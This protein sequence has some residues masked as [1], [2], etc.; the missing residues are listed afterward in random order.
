[1]RRA[2][3]YEY[4]YKKIQVL[5]KKWNTAEELQMHTMSI[6]ENGTRE[7]NKPVSLWNRVP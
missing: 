6:K 3:P 5:Q 7:P 2:I 1:M 4:N